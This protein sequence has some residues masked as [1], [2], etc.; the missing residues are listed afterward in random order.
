MPRTRDYAIMLAIIGTLLVAVVAVGARN[1][2]AK[3]LNGANVFSATSDS[4]VSAE[5]AEAKEPS[6]EDVLND[7]KN[8]VAAYLKNN[9]EPETKA[10]VDATSTPTLP[11]APAE[12]DKVVEQRCGTYSRTGGGW[13]ATDLKIDEVEGA[14]I[15]YR[16]GAVVASTSD[17]TSSR[18][19]VLQLP[20]R[21]FSEGMQHCIGS[22]VIGIAK[23]GSL[24][25][26]SDVSA[27]KVFGGDT[28]VGYALD[29]YPIYGASGDKTDVCGGRVVDGQ[30]R[31]QIGAD[32]KTIIN[33]YAGTPVS[34]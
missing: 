18:D 2:V 1:S 26:N 20:L 11:P 28:L 31:Y 29:G 34:I 8:K 15:V 12:A 27:Y 16:E 9:T 10:A 25:R 33:C 3:L 19:V 17:M 32:S 30:Y 5:V 7:L 24:I 4:A 14:R 21:S 23:G 6:K 13:D 22:D